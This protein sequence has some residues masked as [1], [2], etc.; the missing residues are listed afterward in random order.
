MVHGLGMLGFQLLN[1]L[2]VL[3]LRLGRR[4]LQFL[5]QGRLMMPFALLR[6][7]FQ[8]V[9]LVD[10]LFLGNRQLNLGV[11]MG[12]RHLFQF[13]PQRLEFVFFLLEQGDPIII[14]RIGIVGRSTFGRLRR[15]EYSSSWTRRRWSWKRSSSS[16]VDGTAVGSIAISY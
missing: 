12:R 5:S 2:G 9:R 3:L 10:Q 11:L 8:G 4:Q 7:L 15:L 13:V 16:A 6:G 14:I 1:M